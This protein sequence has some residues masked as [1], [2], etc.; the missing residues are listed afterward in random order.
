MTGNR[1]GYVKG[2]PRLSLVCPIPDNLPKV[3]DDALEQCKKIALTPRKFPELRGGRQLKLLHK[4]KRSWRIRGDR[5]AREERLEALSLVMQRAM[6]G[7]DLITHRVG[8][9]YKDSRFVHGPG[10]RTFAKDCGITRTRAG[11][12][13]RHAVKLGWMTVK[14]GRKEYRPKFDGKCKCCKKG[15]HPPG[16]W[17]KR[18]WAFNNVYRVTE[19]FI[20]ALG[21]S[22]KRKWKREKDKKLARQD[23]ARRLKA[24]DDVAEIKLRRDQQL[25]AAKHARAKAEVEARAQE[26]LSRLE[27][28]EVDRLK[29]ELQREHPDW[30]PGRLELEARRRL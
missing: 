1:C 29:R 30:G 3:F 6:L 22:F 18:W 27:L 2:Q 28:A 26:T 20:A 9:P 14:Q 12:A 13:A 11:R 4:G 8:R 24:V 25:L 23:E 7:A 15:E 17:K 21:Q 10:H 5:L 16:R 19:A